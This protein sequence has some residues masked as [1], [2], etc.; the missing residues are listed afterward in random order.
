QSVDLPYKEESAQEDHHDPC[1]YTAHAYNSR[2]ERNLRRLTCI[3]QMLIDSGLYNH[4]NSAS[5]EAPFYSNLS[6]A[7]S[8]YR[9]KQG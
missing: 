4:Y 1:T 8:L 2:F 5:F 6:A 3:E 9:K 7:C